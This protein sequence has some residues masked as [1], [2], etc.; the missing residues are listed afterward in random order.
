MNAQVL[1]KTTAIMAVIEA[2]NTTMLF[3]LQSS[4]T[5]E[6]IHRKSNLTAY[7]A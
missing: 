7:A 5:P 1:I 6:L 3:G 4:W 2:K